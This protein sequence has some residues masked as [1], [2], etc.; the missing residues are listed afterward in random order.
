[1]SYFSSPAQGH[2]DEA[3]LRLRSFKHSRRPKKKKPPPTYMITARYTVQYSCAVAKPCI[4]S[5]RRD[6]HIW[7]A[8]PIPLDR[9]LNTSIDP[10][11]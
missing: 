3:L 6:P 8:I 4:K 7:P 9:P 1:M 11:L 10:D 5:R 2:S